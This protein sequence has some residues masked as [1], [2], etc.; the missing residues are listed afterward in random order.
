MVSKT[1]TSCLFVS[2]GLFILPFQ[3]WC[4]RHLF[5]SPDK[6]SR[7]RYSWTPYPRSLHSAQHVLQGSGTDLPAPHQVVFT[8][9]LAA[10]LNMDLPSN[11]ID[12]IIQAHNP[13]EAIP[14]RATAVIHNASLA[15]GTLLITTVYKTESSIPKLPLLCNLPQPLLV[16]KG[17]LLNSTTLLVFLLIEFPS[18]C[19]VW[20][21]LFILNKKKNQ[22]YLSN[23]ELEM[24]LSSVCRVARNPIHRTLDSNTIVLGTCQASAL[25]LPGVGADRAEVPQRLQK[26][27]SDKYLMWSDC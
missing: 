15:G 17:K 26:G 25:G 27:P 12:M 16:N 8:H 19:H 14:L 20:G 22:I 11:L 23:V 21:A 9:P 2:G 24:L 18:K 1:T 3:T 5:P 10:L 13:L 4:Y 7:K 6:N